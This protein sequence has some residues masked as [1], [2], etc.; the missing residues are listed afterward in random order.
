L[1]RQAIA[2]DKWDLGWCLLV[3]N[4]QVLRSTTISTYINFTMFVRDK[5]AVNDKENMSNFQLFSI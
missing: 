5:M 4:S 2:I 3:L 1:R